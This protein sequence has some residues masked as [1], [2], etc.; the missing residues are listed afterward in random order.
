MLHYLSEGKRDYTRKRIDVSM[1]S[2]WEF[3]A[4]LSGRMAPIYPDSPKSVET[5]RRNHLWIFAPSV[6]HGWTSPPNRPCRI[7]VIHV[8]T[9]DIPSQ[10]SV[11]CRQTGVLERSLTAQDIRQI[12][13][14]TAEL[15]QH[16]P[17]L[18]SLTGLHTQRLLTELSLIALRDQDLPIS[19][20]TKRYNEQRVRVALTW[21]S[22]NMSQHVGVREMAIAAGVS[23]VQ[24]RRLF[25]QT[26]HQSPLKAIN[27]IRLERAR[28][29]LWDTDQ[30]LAEIAD[31]LGLSGPTVFCR[32]FKQATGYPPITWL[33]MTRD[34]KP[35]TH[36]SLI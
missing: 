16:Y 34:E 23:E 35:A 5:F 36:L 21:F 4:V 33:Q 13:R 3:Q 18:T 9:E 22:Q 6:P 15:R 1:R 32:W 30:S 25:A 29:L 8:D 26:S 14:L 27:A 28:H 10:L 2:G 12:G 11:A 24:L 17:R 7:M 19:D 20:W 31:A